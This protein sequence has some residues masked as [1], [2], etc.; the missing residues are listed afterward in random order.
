MGSMSEIIGFDSPGEFFAPVSS[1]LI[2][3]LVAQYGSMRT[4]IDEV[5][6]IMVGEIAGAVSY[7]FEGNGR[8]SRYGSPA[9][10]ASSKRK[11]PSPR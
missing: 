9:S 11:A 10:S 3:S 7:F 6:D 8:D 2:D 5:A 1:D 4:R